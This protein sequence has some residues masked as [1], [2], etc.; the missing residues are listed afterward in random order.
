MRTAGKF[1]NETT[2]SVSFMSAL[3]TALSLRPAGPRNQGQPL[4]EEEVDRKDMVHLIQ[5]ASAIGELIQV[6]HFRSNRGMRKL[7]VAKADE[8][9]VLIQT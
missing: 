3:H 2:L 4:L 1:P 8:G 5:A 7:L 9:T 6:S